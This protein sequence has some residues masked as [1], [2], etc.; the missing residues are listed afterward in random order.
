MTTTHDVE[1]QSTCRGAVKPHLASTSSIKY[2]GVCAPCARHLVMKLAYHGDMVPGNLVLVLF[3]DIETLK[4]ETGV[5]RDRLA[6][7]D[8]IIGAIGDDL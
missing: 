7:A 4:W 5:L 2:N 8:E 1:P 6:L 3:D